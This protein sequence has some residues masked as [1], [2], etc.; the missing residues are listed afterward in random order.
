[1]R[2]KELTIALSLLLSISCSG[3]Q[4]QQTDS[5]FSDQEIGQLLLIGF[6]GMEV[7]SESPVVRDITKLNLGGVILFDYDVESRA[8]N[9]NIKSKEQ[10]RKLVEQLKGYSTSPLFIA[11]DQEGGQVSRLKSRY[12]FPNTVSAEYLG[13]LD[14]EDSTR[15]Y[16]KITAQELSEL[17]IN[18]NFA[19]VLDVNTNP[20]NPIIARY[21]RSYSSDPGKVAEHAG[22][23][24]EEF[25]NEGIITVLKHFPGHGSST[26]DSHLGI[27][28]V[29]ETWDEIELIPYQHLLDYDGFNA[30]MTAH[31]FNAKIDSVWP[32]TLSSATIDGLLRDSLDYDGLVFSDDMQMEAIRSEY[33]LETAIEQA[34]NAGVDVLVFGNNLVYEED[35]AQRAITI[36]QNLVHNG[37]VSE[38]T[39]QT[40]LNRIEALKERISE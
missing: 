11:I 20:D 5:V 3:R 13:N 38:E 10:L 36:I 19:P 2:I 1:M 40:S 7:D 15:Y 14:N 21:D 4:T 28:D 24:I 9:R 23:V 18:L 27:T 16:A 17:D 30:V 6:R 39:I 22:Y 8:Y 31:I 32:A 35:I 37:K 26:S 25:S 33:G 29:T 34:L 12:G